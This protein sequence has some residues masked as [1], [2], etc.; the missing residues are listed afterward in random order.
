MY[1]QEKLSTLY[2]QLWRVSYYFVHKFF[3]DFEDRQKEIQN[4][5]INLVKMHATKENPG[6]LVVDSTQIKKLYGKKSET[7]ML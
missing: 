2:P 5:L 1:G 4:F 6:V 7:S 3:D